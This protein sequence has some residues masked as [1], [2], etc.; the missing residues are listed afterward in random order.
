M[1]LFTG[2]WSVFAVLNRLLPDAVSRRV[3]SAPTPGGFELVGFTAY[4]DGMDPRRPGWCSVKLASRAVHYVS[5]EVP[6]Y[7]RW[8]N[9]LVLVVRLWENAPRRLEI[10]RLPRMSSSRRKR[11]G[12]PAG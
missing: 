3:L 6:P 2:R 1:R 12:W 4:Y 8:F 9:P 7:F 11:V 5:W 10:E